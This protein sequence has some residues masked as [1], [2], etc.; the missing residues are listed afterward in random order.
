MVNIF[1]K[2]QILCFSFLAL[3]VL[4]GSFFVVPISVLRPV[5]SHFWSVYLYLREHGNSVALRGNSLIWVLL[6]L[7]SADCCLFP[8]RI[9][10]ISLVLCE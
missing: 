4:L 9:S 8:F 3:K 5:S 2:F 7:G 1:L 10:H 6:G